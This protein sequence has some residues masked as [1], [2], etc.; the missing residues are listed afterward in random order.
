MDYIIYTLQKQDISP[1]FSFF[2]TKI[3]YTRSFFAS[4]FSDVYS[5]PKAK[6][7]CAAGRKSQQISKK[8]QNYR[9]GYLQNVI[10]V[11]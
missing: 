10:F 7:N 5:A 6:S 1:L 2:V 11:R 3:L 8:Y 9:R 4:K